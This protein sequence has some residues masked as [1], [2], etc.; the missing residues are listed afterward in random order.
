M[1][2]SV[3]IADMGVRSALVVVRKAPR[4]GS[5]AGLR[6]AAVGLAAP[7]SDKLRPS[8]QFGRAGL[9]AFWDDDNAID[10][11]LAEHPL[12]ARFASG[13]HLRLEP[14]RAFGTWPGL[15]GDVPAQRHV[16]HEGPVA[17]LT[18]GRPRARELIRFV[19][20]TA[21]AS[22]SAVVSPGMLW[23]TGLARPPSF[24]ATCSLWE[25]TRAASTFAYGH[26]N[27]GHPDAIASDQAKPFH[28][29]S[30]FIRFRPYSADGSLGGKNPLSA[31][32]APE[33]Q[34]Q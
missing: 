15:P 26:G 8:V 5:I 24:V 4:A 6:S 17:V 11:F 2:A 19:R 29:E 33:L 22:A 3:H 28:H 14:L 34:G 23:G 31:G 9:I 18:L 21:K 1:I 12:A 27:P 20:T 32:L 16:D 13:W 30:A 10:R 25:S 7:L